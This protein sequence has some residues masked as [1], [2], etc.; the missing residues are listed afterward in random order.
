[1]GF[2]TGIGFPLG[3]QSNLDLRLG[4]SRDDMYNYT[5]D[6][7]IIAAEAAQGALDTMSVGYTFEYDNRITGLNPKGGV[8]LRSVRTSRALAVT[9]NM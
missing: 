5:G 8:L 7:P 6:S 1:M 3:E 4:F 2:T 9:P